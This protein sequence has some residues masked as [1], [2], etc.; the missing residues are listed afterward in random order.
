[1]KIIEVLKKDNQMSHKLKK[2][3]GSVKK[4]IFELLS[5]TRYTADSEPTID[6]F[7]DF[8]QFLFYLE[9]RLSWHQ[10]YIRVTSS[11]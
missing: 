5:D 10:S 3:I 4:N 1:M 2:C 9:I 11:T 7:Q 8:P 6:L